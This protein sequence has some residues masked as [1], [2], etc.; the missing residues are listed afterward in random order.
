MKTIK[1]TTSMDML[2]RGFPLIELM[3]DVEIIGIHASIAIPAYQQ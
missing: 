2:V 1:R 3:I